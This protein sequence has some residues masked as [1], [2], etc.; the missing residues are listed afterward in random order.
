MTPYAL[1]LVRPTDDDDA[2]RRRFHALIRAE[3]PDGGGA[4]G[5]PGTMWYVLKSAY[6]AVKTEA[7]RTAWSRAHADALLLSGLCV[8]CLGYGV[9][10]RR[11][12]LAA[13]QGPTVCSVC[14]GE[15]RV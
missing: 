5:T 1:L 13:R 12:G 10:W 7:L 11:T 14:N 6:E 8:N 15:G 3:H 4:Q 2:I 9:T